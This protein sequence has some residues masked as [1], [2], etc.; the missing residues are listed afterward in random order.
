MS[1][2]RLSKHF[3]KPHDAPAL[4]A[5]TYRWFTEGLHTPDLREAGELVKQLT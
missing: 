1:L 4:L 2:A 3:G 5:E